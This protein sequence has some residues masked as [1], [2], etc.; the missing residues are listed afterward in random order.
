MEA[1][2]NKE[3]TKWLKQNGPL[4]LGNLV[5]TKAGELK[6]KHII[7]TLGAVAGMADSNQQLMLC[8]SNILDKADELKDVETISMP[9]IS[10]CGVGFEE[11]LC[12][13]IMI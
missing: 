9:P 12:A 13:E 2:I 7:H 4:Q 1:P 5:V 10:C 8:V 11:D 6:C 3:C